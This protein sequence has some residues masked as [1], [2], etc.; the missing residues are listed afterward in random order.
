MEKRMGVGALQLAA[1]DGFHRILCGVEGCRISG[2]FL[3][4]L[5]CMGEGP[6]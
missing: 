2:H 6:P 3:P 4:G 5:S 1:E